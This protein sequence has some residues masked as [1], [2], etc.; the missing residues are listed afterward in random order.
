MSEI[1]TEFLFETRIV[2]E[3]P[4]DLGQTPEG[5]R[6]IFMVKSAQFEGPR[7]RGEVIP[8]SGADWSRLRPDGSGVIDVRMCLKTHDGAMIYAHWHGLMVASPEDL[9]YALD[10]AKSDDPQGAHRYY[11]RCSPVF[12]TGDERYAWLNHIVA[13]TTSRTGDGGVI[14]RVFAVK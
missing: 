4:M 9:G 13:V 7:M 8:L 10:F 2:L 5:R 12:E 14:H 3:A 11:F 1:E 6:L